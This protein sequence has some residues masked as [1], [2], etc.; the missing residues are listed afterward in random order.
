MTIDARSQHQIHSNIEAR[1]IKPRENEPLHDITELKGLGKELW[2]KLML[3]R[4]WKRN[5]IHGMKNRS[6]SMT[7]Y[8]QLQ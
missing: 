3:M 5:V 2:E 7:T 6:Y 8:T 1:R 4:T